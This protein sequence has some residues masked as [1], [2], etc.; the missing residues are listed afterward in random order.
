MLDNDFNISLIGKSQIKK[1][2]HKII[3]VD[4]N[5]D[6]ENILYLLTDTVS[7]ENFEV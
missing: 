5:Q 7:V 1:P 6:I 2:Q 3:L 4:L